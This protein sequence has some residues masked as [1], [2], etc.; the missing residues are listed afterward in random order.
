MTNHVHVLWAKVRARVRMRGIFWFWHGLTYHVHKDPVECDK[1][2]RSL[3]KWDPNLPDAPPP[4]MT[5]VFNELRMTI[6]IR[7]NKPCPLVVEELG[8]EYV[9]VVDEFLTKD[10]IEQKEWSINRGIINSVTLSTPCRV[11]GDGMAIPLKGSEL[12]MVAFNGPLCFRSFDN[13]ID[14][15]DLKYD[16]TRTFTPR[17]GMGN[18]FTIAEFRLALERNLQGVV[19]NL[20]FL[21]RMYL[22]VYLPIYQTRFL[23]FGGTC[24]I[25]DG[26][27]QWK[28][29]V[30]EARW[31]GV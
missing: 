6:N 11:N 20:H 17:Q 2:M 7:Y 29:G 15:S 30:Y 16:Y 26:L 28:P 3:I 8:D 18:C 27:V 12:D 10:E 5:D 24:N 14:I 9:S 4:G 19:M 1:R 23:N 22:P 13:S 31:R 25:F 21:D